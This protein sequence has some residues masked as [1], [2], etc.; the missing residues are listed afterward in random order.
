MKIL[1]PSKIKKMDAYNFYKDILINKMKNGESILKFLIHGALKKNLLNSLIYFFLLIDFFN[2]ILFLLKI[3]LENLF[4]KVFCKKVFCWNKVNNGMSTV[5][6]PPLNTCFCFFNRRT[7]LR[8]YKKTRVPL[9]KKC[10][11]EFLIWKRYFRF[12]GTSDEDKIIQNN[13]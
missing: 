10:F 2:S 8:L 13:L 5:F 6:I 9:V 3:T 4:I 12:P 11:V 1:I 7:L